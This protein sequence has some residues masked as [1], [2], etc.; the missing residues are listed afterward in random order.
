MKQIIRLTESDLHRVIK[1]SV[2]RVLNEAIGFLKDGTVVLDAPNGETVKF[3]S[4]EDY[5]NHKQEYFDLSQSEKQAPNGNGIIEDFEKLVKNYYQ[6]AKQYLQILSE[7]DGKEYGAKLTIGN[8]FADKR[9]APSIIITNNGHQIGYIKII[10][11][12]DLGYI[13]L[14]VCY[15]GGFHTHWKMEDPSKPQE[16]IECACRMA[17]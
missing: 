5:E 11:H 10:Q 6:I 15:I 1:E 4:Y 16:D 17:T 8:S 12:K 14:D 9:I 13:E 2:N 3:K 7:K